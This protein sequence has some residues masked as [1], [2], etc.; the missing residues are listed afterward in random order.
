MVASDNKSDLTCVLY[1]GGRLRL[2]SRRVF[3]ILSAFGALCKFTA[4]ESSRPPTFLVC[5]NNYTH[6]WETIDTLDGQYTAGFRMGLAYTDTSYHASRS[7]ATGTQYQDY[8]VKQDGRDQGEGPCCPGPLHPQAHSTTDRNAGGSSSG[9]SVFQLEDDRRL[10]LDVF[11]HKRL[12]TGD[13]DFRTSRHDSG[14][15]SAGNLEYG[16]LGPMNPLARSV[17]STSGSQDVEEG[18]PC[19]RDTI[20]Q[21]GD[22][23]HSQLQVPGKNVIDLERIEHG[24]DTRTTV[25]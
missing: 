12:I 22:G 10:G 16:P 9:R 8:T 2:S 11:S 20:S 17:V 3:H 13:S 21:G 4:I 1:S 24:L 25:R 18:L 7:Q 19:Y 14:A 15:D 5:F 6:G 23:L